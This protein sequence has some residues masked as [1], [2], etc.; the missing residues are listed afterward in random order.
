LNYDQKKKVAVITG[1][2]KGLE[3]AVTTSFAKSNDYSD[4]ITNSRKIDEAQ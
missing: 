4:I 3:K 1:S 2:S